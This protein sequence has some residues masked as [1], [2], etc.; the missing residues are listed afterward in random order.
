ML[1][2]AIS[3]LGKDNEKL[4]VINH[5][6]K[7]KCESQRTSLPSD[8]E[9]FFCGLRAKKKTLKFGPGINYK[10]SRFPEKIEFA[11]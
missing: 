3:A 2:G 5:Q 6:F 4:R 8:K 11:T 9:T 1:L 7:V 10:G